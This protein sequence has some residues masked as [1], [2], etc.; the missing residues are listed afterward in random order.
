MKITVSQ[1]RRII[2]E[3]VSRALLDKGDVTLGSVEDYRNKWR[4]KFKEM[5]INPVFGGVDWSDPA[6]LA[7]FKNV[8]DISEVPGYKQASV[9]FRKAGMQLPTP[10]DDYVPSGGP[11]RPLP[12]W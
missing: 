6:A 12:N 9:A 8:S 3:E 11:D 5:G 4:K 7:K 10:F 2:K 1:L